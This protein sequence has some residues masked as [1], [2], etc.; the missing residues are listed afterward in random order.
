MLSLPGGGVT[1]HG[2]KLVVVAGRIYAHMPSPVKRLTGD[3]EALLLVHSGQIAPYRSKKRFRVVV[4]GRRWGK[5]HWVCIELVNA[6]AANPNQRCWYV[7]PTYSMAKQIAWEKLK[8]IIPRN[9]I[10]RNYAGMPDVNETNLSIKLIN[11]SR[12][13]LKGADKP[14]SLRGVGINFLALD[15]FQ[16]MKEGVWTAIRPTLTDTKGR[17]IFIGT[18]KSFNHLYKMYRRG[19]AGGNPQW[20]SWQ[21]KTGDSPF[22]S[23][24]E[25]EQAR[26]DMDARK[27]RQ[28]YEA[29]FES[30]SGRIY[31]D[32]LQD[33]NVRPCPFDPALPL[34]VGQDFNVDPMSTVICQLHGDEVWAT[35]ELSLRSSSTE[36]VC[37]ELIREF[38]NDVTRR[39][40]IYPDPSGNNRQ[41]ARG[42][43][44]VQIFREWGFGRILFSRKAPLLRDRYASVNRLICDASGR[45]R[46]YVDPSCKEL[47]TCLEQLIYKEGTNDPDKDLGI[48]HMGDA[49][50]Y[51]VHH[52][53]PVKKRPVYMGGS[54]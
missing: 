47:I 4:A 9:W 18:P 44:D 34:Y 29:S 17:C 39:A 27:F 30:M 51:F 28:E 37:S 6:A 48:D 5:T 33:H 52:E 13:T 8:E 26:S 24:K 53:F 45:R 7:A 21:F 20:E 36:D 42:E 46:L 32:F 41:H 50:G 2:V 35:G 40:T 12:I 22:I 43:S 49:L 31:Y 11:G 14:D 23:R 16:D 3:D 19:L 25:I 10:A 1:A 15:E 38:G 54:H